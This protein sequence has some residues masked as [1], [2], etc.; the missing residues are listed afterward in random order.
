MTS[1]RRRAPATS[2]SRCGS[3][4]GSSSRWRSRP[5]LF[6]QLCMIGGLDRY[7]QIAT[8]WRDE[9]LRA[10]RQFEFRQLDLE[11]AF[12][13]REDVLDVMEAA[14]SRRVRGSRPRAARAAVPADGLRRG[15]RAVRHGQARPALRARDPGRD[16]GD[17]RLRVRGVRRTRHA[18]GS[19]S[20]RRS[21]RVPSS[22]GWRRSRRSGGRRGSHTSSTAP[23]ARSRSPIAK[24]LSERELAAFAAPAGSTVLF[25]AGEPATGRARAR[26][27][28]PARGARARPGRPARTSSTG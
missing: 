12:V 14:S 5:Q 18:C 9:D 24:F 2:S 21:T 4:P 27:A 28:A 20:F 1:G 16:R 8:C 10:D 13:E 17:A 7:Y 22:A 15:D 3:S 19:S 26:R 25:G 6:K 23:T 11:M